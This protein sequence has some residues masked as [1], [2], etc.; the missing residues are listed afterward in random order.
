MVSIEA[1]RARL[2]LLDPLPP[3]EMRR[4]VELLRRIV[5]ATADAPQPPEKPHLARSRSVAPG[6]DAP[7]ATLIDQYLTDLALFRDD[8]HTEAW[9]PFNLAGST[10]ETFTYLWRG[11]ADTV[12]TLAERLVRREHPRD[13]YL[14]AL[15]DLVTRGWVA[16]ETGRY[17][18]TDQGRAIREEAEQA[19]NRVFYAAWSC[20]NDDELDELRGLPDRH[21]DSLRRMVNEPIPA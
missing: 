18:L 11:E 8:A 16:E 14:Q 15:D 21:R 20:L 5:Y 3:A 7:A 1:A 6:E 2:A 12:D 9:R 17:S 19:T 13:V 10:W 4:T